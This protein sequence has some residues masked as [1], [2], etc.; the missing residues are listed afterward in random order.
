M[1]YDIYLRG[2][3][4]EH[5]S[6]PNPTYNLTEIFDHAL[7]EE[8]L[9]NPDI[10][11]MQVVLFR[12]KTDR[13]RGLRLLSGKTG[14]ETLEWIERAIRCLED[15]KKRKTFL[16]LQP[17]NGWGDLPGAIEVMRDLAE[18]AKDYPLSVWEI[19]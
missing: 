12:E 16:A 10:T 6:L 5:D 2:D 8:N 18:A 7:T 3:S 11:E 13:P 14:A 1:S 19:R 15:P 4:G 9:P 17:S